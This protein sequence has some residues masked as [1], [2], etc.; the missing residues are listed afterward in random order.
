MGKGLPD[1]MQVRFP[2]IYESGRADTLDSHECLSRH[3]MDHPTSAL[4]CFSVYQTW[5]TYEVS[6]DAHIKDISFRGAFDVC[7][8]WPLQLCAIQSAKP[9]Y[10]NTHGPCN[11]HMVI[12][13]F[14][15]GTTTQTTISKLW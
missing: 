15:P 2:D 10:G 13:I 5:S 12:D 11:R 8:D 1:V 7:R 9:G 4:S 6:S 14:D 3:H